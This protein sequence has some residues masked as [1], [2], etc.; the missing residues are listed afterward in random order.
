[1]ERPLSTEKQSSGVNPE[2][3]P[4]QEHPSTSYEGNPPTTY[5]DTEKTRW[6]RLWPVIACGAG[7]FSDG[8]LNGVIGFVSTMLGKI[9]PVAYASSPAQR[10]V[11]SIT[12]AGTVVGILIFGYTSDH[13]SR[14]WSF[15]A[16]T[17][18]LILFAALSAGSYGAGGSSSG[19]F[20]AL[21]A[22]RFLLGIGIGGEYPAG[23][24]GCAES[25]GE[26]KSGTRNR[27]F[28]L[29]TNVQIDIGFVVSALV[30]MIVVLC[31]GEDHLRAAWRICLGLGVIPPL[32]LLY[33]RLKLN[34]PEAYRRETMAKAKT[35]WLLV[36]K[37]YWWRLTI[38]SLIWFIYDF[39]GYSFSLFSSTIVDNLL[40][41]NS[42]LWKTFG[43]TTLIY[44]FYLP[45]CIG[46]SFVSDWLGPKLTLGI[47]VLA[48]GIVGFIMAGVY[49]YLARP[50]NVA[51]FVIVYGVFLALG[52]F[53][54]GDNIGLI[55]SKSCATAV[56]GQYYGI[57]AAIGKIGAFVGDQVLAILY[58][59]YKDTDIVKA[60]QYP[61]FVS[62]ALC[63][64]SAFIAFFL[65]PHIGQD[66]I[67]EEDQKFRA[68]LAE[69]GY[70]ISQMGVQ[71]E[72]ADHI[73]GQSEV[74]GNEEMSERMVKA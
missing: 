53:G 59:R 24:V 13:Y 16:S 71:Q 20:A 32:S 55:A 33:L 9:Y 6:E 39:S 38:V 15:F 7:L 29:F 67:D 61:F 19:L 56:R 34:E 18:I 74:E 10:N 73:V 2:I 48:Q 43:W 4:V 23:S 1:M 26:L 36:L 42:A 40:R 68:Y 50:S 14:K 64:L 27:W 70:D 37:F 57:A 58:D 5:E 62:S 21:T 66:T 30:P 63:I 25:T 35:P 52:E 3:A 45:G 11:S 60:G 41:D 51:G 28:I 46:G 8:Y 31:T 22:W 65:L 54:P 69:H 12:F 49:S 72:S 47:G 44:L 17:V